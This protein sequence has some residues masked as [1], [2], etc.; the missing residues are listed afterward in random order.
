MFRSAITPRLVPERSTTRMAV[1]LARIAPTPSTQMHR[2]MPSDMAPDEQEARVDHVVGH[3]VEHDQDRPRAR[4][5]AGRQGQQT[6]FH[7][8]A[9]IVPVTVPVP[10]PVVPVSVPVA[11]VVSVTVPMAVAVAV[12]MAVPV[13]GSVVSGRAR[14]HP[15]GLIEHVHADAD[16]DQEARRAHARHLGESDSESG[17]QDG[18]RQPH[19]DHGRD[20]VDDRDLERP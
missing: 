11:V 14:R 9:V 16:D 5:H 19:D 10:V 7:A 20:D 18:V 2:P 17:P 15:H 1:C 12:P 6:A 4:H 8:A 13:S 3:R